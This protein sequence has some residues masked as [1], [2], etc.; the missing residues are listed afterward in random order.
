MA[1]GKTFDHGICNY[2]RCQSGEKFSLQGEV[3]KARKNQTQTNDQDIFLL[4]A[5][6]KERQ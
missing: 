1:V 2:H 3:N 5:N 4:S 6:F